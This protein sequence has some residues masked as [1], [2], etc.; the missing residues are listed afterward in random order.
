MRLA[1]LL[2]V[3]S[4]RHP[5]APVRDTGEY[6]K[7]GTGFTP[8]Q[9]CAMYISRFLPGIL[10]PG[11]R[12]DKSCTVNIAET[13]TLLSAMLGMLLE[14]A[15]P[16]MRQDAGF[17]ASSAALIA[18]CIYSMVT[19]TA[20][21]AVR[22]VPSQLPLFGSLPADCCFMSFANTNLWDEPAHRQR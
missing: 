11:G 18:T 3:T 1:N 13:W 9:F 17:A 8:C 12:T 21:D 10:A 6:I 14:M 5:G 2:R 4:R 15:P 16:F 7:A 20:Q 22:S 19:G